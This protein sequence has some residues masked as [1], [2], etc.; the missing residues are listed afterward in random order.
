MHLKVLSQWLAEQLVI[1]HLSR[2]A[3]LLRAVGALLTGGKLSLTHIGRSL[4]GPA[5][6]K[7]QIKAADRLLGNRHLGRERDGIYRAIIQTLLL[8]NRR[9][10]I[11]VDW[12]D[13]QTGRQ[14]AML[15]AA[16]PVG[17]RAIS[18]YERVFPF[19]RYN[20]PGAHREFLLALR[21]VLPQDCRPI[22]VTDAGFRGPWF[23]EVESY[24]WDWIGRV[25]SN[26]KYY[27]EETARWSLVKSLYPQATTVPRHIGDVML[28]KHRGYRAG[29]YLVRA[30][31]IRLG[32]PR[33]R[34]KKRNNEVAYR[35]AHREPWLLA[36]SLAHTHGSARRVSHLY[37]KRMQIEETFRDLKCHRW[38]FGLCYSR[39]NNIRRLEALLLLAAL[40]TLVAWLVGLAARSLQLHRHLQA[41]TER[42]REVLSTF[43]IG[44]ELLRRPAH[45]LRPP[46]IVRALTMLR[47]QILEA[48]PA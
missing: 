7:H 10:V 13:F 30:H 37:S 36:T 44:R 33:R 43:F 17:G 26:V 12:S 2:T 18:L 47:R 23:R 27:R 28:S 14:W 6:V 29:L 41:N 16:V 15:K 21:S 34:P 40:A 48:I 35:R 9:P 20:S 1:G 45:D 8:G 46:L 38:G 11:V 32:R 4:D 3:A 19:K 22:I 31:K 39:C 5:H 42:R 24:G 25:R